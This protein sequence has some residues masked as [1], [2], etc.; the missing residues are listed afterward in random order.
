M[1]KYIKH[2]LT[3]TECSVLLYKVSNIQD[4]RLSLKLC[5]RF[6]CYSLLLLGV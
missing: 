5:S 6:A 3:K 4:T 1:Y 2:L